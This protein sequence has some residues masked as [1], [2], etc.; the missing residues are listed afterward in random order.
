MLLQ[1]HFVARKKPV[2]ERELEICQRLLHFR[3]EIR[4]TRRAMAE[5][6]GIDPKR[7]ETYE[8][9]RVPLPYEIAAKLGWKFKINPV[10]LAEGTEIM[11]VEGRNFPAPEIESKI[12]PRTLFSTAYD[13]YIEPSLLK[14]ARPVNSPNPQRQL[15][16]DIESL[17]MDKVSVK[18]KI[19]SLSDLMN[20]LRRLTK[21]RGQKAALARLLGVS[22]QAVDQWLD[23]AKPSAETTFAL[24]NWVEQQER[25][26]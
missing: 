8:A 5:V 16:L 3:K 7:L 14:K 20:A 18:N 15:G 12:R 25:Q 19:R 2:P 1:S 17:M 10:H 11:N 22:R 24:L 21:E 4:L 6:L 26:K 9:G 13:K 23:G